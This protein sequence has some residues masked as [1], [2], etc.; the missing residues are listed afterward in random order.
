MATFT[1]TWDAAYE[2]DPAD[3]D[4]AKLLGDDVRDV[5]R[6]VRERLEIDHSWAGD[7]DDGTHKKATL[8]PQAGDPTPTSSAGFIY[9][10]D[11]GGVTELF[12]MDSDG[13]ANVIQLTAGGVLKDVVNTASGVVSVA[14]ILAN[15]AF[16][17]GKESGG[18]QRN[19]VGMNASDEIEVGVTDNPLRLKSSDEPTID[20][21]G[22]VLTPHGHSARHTDQ[23]TAGPAGIDYIANILQAIHFD[24]TDVPSVSA[25]DK[26]T[27]V[28]DMTG[29]RGTS[30]VLLI[31]SGSA[32]GGAGNQV[33]FT[34]AIH[35]DASPVGRS[36]I[37]DAGPVDENDIIS[38]T[39][40]AYVTALTAASH[41]FALNVS[42][43]NMTGAARFDDFQMLTL[44]LGVE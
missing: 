28:I 44:D 22:D 34:A 33:N 31:A 36:M 38:F 16:L 35:A 11:V 14:L 2:A 8:L 32:Q 37:L 4:Q 17:I 20:A 26:V 23:T 19:L 6:D 1:I 42:S 25:G 21:A 5:K 10:K 41:T 40:L 24:D 27:R 3:G 9:A 39:L 13:P 29:R 15:N 12:Y 18:T 30:H 7:G 43:L